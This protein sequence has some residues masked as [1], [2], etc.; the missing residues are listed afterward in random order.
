MTM[1]AMLD[2]EPSWPISGMPHDGLTPT[3][4]DEGGIESPLSVSLLEECSSYNE[5]FG[6]PRIQNNPTEWLHTR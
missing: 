2:N 5:W 4:A 3:G 6:F 1:L